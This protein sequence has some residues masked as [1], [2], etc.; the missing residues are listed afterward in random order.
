M[1]NSD[2]SA[3]LPI[4]TGRII[5]PPGKRL[6][7]GKRI[8]AG[9]YGV[10]YKA[11]DLL[12][13]QR[14]TYAVKCLLKHEPGGALAAVQDRE[15]CLHQAVSGHRNIVTLHDVVDDGRYLYFVLDFCSGGD[16]FGAIIDRDAFTGYDQTIKRSHSQLEVSLTF[17]CGSQFYMSPECI[18]LLTRIY[19]YSPR[20]ADIWA[21]GVILVNLMTGRN[22][23]HVASSE[24]DE[25]FAQYLKDGAFY[26]H[27]VIPVTW[28]LALLLERVFDANPS[29]RITLPDLREAI[30]NLDTLYRPGAEGMYDDECEVVPSS[31]WDSSAVTRPPTAEIIIQP[32]TS[33][34]DVSPSSFP[35]P[36]PLDPPSSSSS[37]GRS[38]NDS[39]GP[40]TPPPSHA[41]IEYIVVSD[42]DDIDGSSARRHHGGFLRGH[43]RRIFSGIGMGI[44]RSSGS[45]SR[46]SRKLHQYKI[47]A[48]AQRFVGVMRELKLRA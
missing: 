27:K 14:K 41:P 35:S 10:V 38:G 40:S 24:H 5:T 28:Q 11:D 44:G 47:G 21:L 25:G 19:A 42:E 23:W 15:I 39:G 6:L 46:L 36:P 32:R 31:A 48:G 16:L 2:F 4:F 17:G 9:A 13:P 43:R 26:L 29:T 37:S 30:I 8:G 34:M 1:I 7:I 33:A 3:I 45:G 18:G 12:D 22:P 20:A